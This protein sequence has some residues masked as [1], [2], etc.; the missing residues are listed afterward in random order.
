MPQMDQGYYRKKIL[1]ENI[2]TQHAHDLS[3]GREKKKA[4][5]VSISEWCSITNQYR[6]KND[7]QIISDL[8]VTKTNEVYGEVT[9]VHTLGDMLK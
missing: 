5:I 3:Q 9:H 8:C 6:G 1:M 2:L 7:H 4:L